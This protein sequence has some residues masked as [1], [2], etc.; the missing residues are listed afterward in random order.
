METGPRVDSTLKE[1]EGCTHL[2]GVGAERGDFTLDRVVAGILQAGERPRVSDC[3][4]IARQEERTEPSSE[5]L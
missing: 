3:P 5:K 1:Q 4:R 2:S